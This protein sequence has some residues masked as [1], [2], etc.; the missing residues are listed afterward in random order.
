MWHLLAVV[1]RNYRF[2]SF[3]EKM[4]IFSCKKFEYINYLM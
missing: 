3:F 2:G 1:M 4:R